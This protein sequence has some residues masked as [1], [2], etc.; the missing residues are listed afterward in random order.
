MQ[1]LTTENNFKQIECDYYI[2][3][4]VTFYGILGFS[5]LILMV[6]PWVFH[7]QKYKFGSPRLICTTLYYGNNFKK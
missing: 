7:L 4:C 6:V 3:G 5:I 2:Q 1:N